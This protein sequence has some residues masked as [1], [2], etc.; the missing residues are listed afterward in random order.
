MN[1]WLL[2][3]LLIASPACQSV[4]ADEHRAG[5][6]PPAAPRTPPPSAQAIRVEVA[7]VQTG[8]ARLEVVLPGEVEGGRDALLAAAFGGF[9][10]RVSVANGQRV[11][12]GAVLVTVD[13]QMQRV[14]RD[15]AAAELHQ[16][17]AD[18]AREQALRGNIPS[19]QIEAAQTR[20]TLASAAARAAAI[21][22]DRSIVKAPFD[23][24]VAAVEAEV[25]EVAA[26]GAPLVRLVQTDP[27]KVTVSVPDRDV[28]GL[29]PGMPVTIATEA[30]TQ[31]LEA[32]I[33]RVSPTSDLRTRAFEAE[34]EVENPEGRLLPGMIATVRVSSAVA[35]GAV[36]LP[37]DLLVTRREGVGVFVV[38]AD[39]AHYRALELGQVIGDQVVVQ[40]G[41]TAG[42][43]IVVTGQRQLQDGDRLIVAR[44]GTCCTAGRVV[45][46][47]PAAGAAAR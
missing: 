5:G 6:P 7:T 32:T 2:M 36:V 33:T 22:L 13:S 31:R 20:V 27:V 42:E 24:V 14:R 37:Q 11:R 41:V 18:F 46:E 17:E 16:A 45:F 47:E 26:P 10:E 12:R 4:G 29:R 35:S 39:R 30:Q 19:A 40:A 25:G 44:E 43:R 34:I 23:G 9:I 21:Q 38:D 8:D 15:Q 3:C 1:R 28:V